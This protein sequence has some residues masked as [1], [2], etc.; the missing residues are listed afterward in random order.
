MARNVLEIGLAA[1]TF[2]RKV[3]TGLLEDIPEDQLMYQPTPTANHALWVMGH[4]A[5]T[6]EFFLREAGRRQVK[7]LEAW[8]DLFF[9]GSTPKSSP[10]DYPAR[11]EIRDYLGVSRRDLMDWF[12]SLSEAELHAPLP[13][14]FQTFGRSPAVLMTTIACHE[15]VHAGQLT[16]VRKGLGIGPKFG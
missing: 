12:K 11:S 9:M 1:L 3:T 14:D 16:L 10:A 13:Q 6:D 8:K 2:A 4:V 5:I 15:C 7:K